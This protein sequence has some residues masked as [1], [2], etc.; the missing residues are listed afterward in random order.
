MTLVPDRR[1]HLR[2][3][4]TGMQL[5][6]VHGLNF[7]CREES[8]SEDLL[9]SLVDV[10]NTSKNGALIELCTK[11]QPGTV[12]LFVFYDASIHRWMPHFARV[13][14]SQPLDSGQYLV[15]LIFEHDCRGRINVNQ[16]AMEDCNRFGD[17]LFL[18]RSSLLE[19]LPQNAFL[20]LINV[21]RK[22]VFEP[23]QKIIAQG[24][25][26]EFLF[27]IQE[28]TCNLLVEK[29]GQTLHIDHLHEGEVVGEVS[30]ITDELQSSN[31][32][33]ET[34]VTAWQLSRRRFEDLAAS[35]P[36]LRDFL[37]EIVT[38]RLESWRVTADRTIGKYAIKR[39]IGKGG[40][41]IVYEG[42]HS[43]LDM[44]VVIKMLKHDMAMNALFLNVFRR[45]ANVIAKFSHKNIVR[46]YDIEERF[47]TVFIIMEKLDGYPLDE[48]LAKTG[49][50]PFSRA[51]DFLLQTCEGLAYAHERGVVH[52]DIKPANL[53][54]QF[55]GQLKIL[56]FGLACPPGTEDLSIAGT[57]HYAPPEQIEGNPADVRSDIYSLGITAYELVTGTR[58]FPE[59]DL[60]R[61]MDLHTEQDIPDPAER[62]SD[63]PPALRAFILGCGR[64][65]PARRLQTATEAGKALKSFFTGRPRDRRSK[66]ML[67][68]HLFYDEEQRHALNTLLEEFSGKAR[69]LGVDLKSAMFKD[70]G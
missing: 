39:R 68:L 54:I 70:I 21:L 24:E 36:D 3:S 69:L 9:Y 14:W 19:A 55:D 57:P 15:G 53:F 25:P 16:R 17:L 18:L 7:I 60:A 51:A 6:I 12:F 37:T 59:D 10:H 66:E 41:S 67:S 1:K 44:P 45:E 38:R 42:V 34:R 56:D 32:V 30:L 64:R 58:P 2:E 29:E 35:Y 49:R 31:V 47:R 65:D 61:L 33:A 8:P 26:G 40:W 52:R 22:R 5:G 20:R 62:I 4:F 48:L 28:G 46:V 27:L 23:G 13:A 43:S 50:L 63:I 11:V